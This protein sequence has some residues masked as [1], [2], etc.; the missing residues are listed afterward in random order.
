MKST[1]SFIAPDN[2][3]VDL[4]KI[5]LLHNFTKNTLKYDFNLNYD[6]LEENFKINL[7][8]NENTLYVHPTINVTMDQLNILKHVLSTLD[9]IE[10]WSL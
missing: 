9:F 8:T 4:L 3:C 10:G 2:L 6:N 7:W 1:Y 5:L